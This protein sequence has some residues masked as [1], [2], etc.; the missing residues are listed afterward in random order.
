MPYNNQY[1]RSS[2]FYALGATRFLRHEK[3]KLLNFLGAVLHAYIQS[4]TVHTVSVSQS[5]MTQ[6]LPT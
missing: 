4:T 1:R 5:T 6:T 3:Q 2:R